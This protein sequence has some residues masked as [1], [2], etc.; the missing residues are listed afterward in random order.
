MDRAKRLGEFALI[1]RYFRPLAAGRPGALGL[2]DDA[3]LIDVPQGRRLAVTTDLLTAGVHFLPDD[4]PDL[5]ARKALRVNLSDLAAMAA[6]PLAYFLAAAFPVEIDESWIAGFAAGLAQDQAE[7]D[8]ALMGGDTTATAGPLTLAVTALGTVEAGRELR[9][10]GAK[11]GD[12]VAVSGTIGD[13]VLGLARLQGRLAPLAGD[14]HLIERYRLPQPRLALAQ[15][16]IGL[17]TAG[18]DVSDGLIADLG[19]IC[20]TSGLSAIIEAKR[21]PL[22]PPAEKA[23]ARDPSLLATLL[24]GG[25]DYEL[26]FT[27]PAEREAELAALPVTIIGRMEPGQ[28]VTVLDPTGRPMQLDRAGFQHF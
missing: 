15:Q 20:E 9:R 19:H 5:I 27:A 14:E 16:L 8:V 24:T 3:A 12:L 1:E 17:A 23:L 13:G 26:L 2:A 11:A 28:G 22:S 18:L 6:R 25:D 21:V 7:F 4:P 10:S